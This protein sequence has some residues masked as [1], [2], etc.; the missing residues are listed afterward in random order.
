MGVSKLN[1]AKLKSSRLMN[2]GNGMYDIV[3]GPNCEALFEACRWALESEMKKEVVFRVQLERAVSY[4][5]TK[6]QVDDMPIGDWRGLGI[7]HVADS[8]D[9]LLIEGDCMADLRFIAHQDPVYRRQR[10][11]AQYDTKL[12]RGMIAFFEAESSSED[13]RMSLIDLAQDTYN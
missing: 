8:K 7:N 6:N 11:R 3:E 13:G 4:D 12:F 5:A 10:F 2:S 9:V 1:K